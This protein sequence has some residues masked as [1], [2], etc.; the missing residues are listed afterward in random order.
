MPSAKSKA[1]DAMDFHALE[2]WMSTIKPD[3]VVNCIGILQKQADRALFGL[4]FLLIFR[5]LLLKQ[6]TLLRLTMHQRMMLFFRLTW[7]T[8]RLSMFLTK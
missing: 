5:V 3:V 7:L 8:A 1:I 6:M 4:M 2:D